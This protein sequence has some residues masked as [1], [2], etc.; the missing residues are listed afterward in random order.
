MNYIYIYKDSFNSACG[1][2]TA[3]IEKVH[4]LC[5]RLYWPFL[6][7]PSLQGVNMYITDSSYSVCGV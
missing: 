1:R 6:F 4:N 3:E 2:N 5:P 7:V